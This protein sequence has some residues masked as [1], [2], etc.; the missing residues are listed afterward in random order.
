MNLSYRKHEVVDSQKVEILG[1]KDPY[2]WHHRGRDPKEKEN[3]RFFAKLVPEAIKKVKEGKELDEDEK[4]AYTIF[5]EDGPKLNYDEAY[6]TYTITDGRHRMYMLREQGINL[7][8]DVLYCSNFRKKTLEDVFVEVPKQ[9]QEEITVEDEIKDE[10]NTKK[11][12]LFYIFFNK[13]LHINNEEEI[14]EKAKK[15]CSNIIDTLAVI[16]NEINKKIL[17]ELNIEY[18][19][20]Y[21]NYLVVTDKNINLEELIKNFESDQIFVSSENIRQ[22]ER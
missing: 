4:Y 11:R 10:K 6:D 20:T 3:L 19:T 9:E 13:T 21:S 17:D 8:M 7:E 15:E 12:S 5:V 18:Y 22:E 14:I 16:N 1:E 2:F